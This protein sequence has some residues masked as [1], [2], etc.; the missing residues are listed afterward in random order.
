MPDE[1]AKRQDI[2]QAVNA[3]RSLSPIQVEVLTDI[4]AKFAEEQ[5]SEHIRNDFLDEDAFEY[6]STRLAAH[7]ASSGV[8]LKKENF[9]HILEQSFKS[10]FGKSGMS[11]SA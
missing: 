2:E 8:A 5:I 9:E 7:H 10:P 11:V 4:I 1:N 3:L 6:F